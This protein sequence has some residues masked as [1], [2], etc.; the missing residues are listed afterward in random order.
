M[1][2]ETKRKDALNKAVEHIGM[3]YGIVSK[4]AF[5]D[6]LI[7]A[8]AAKPPSAVAEV[9]GKVLSPADG[10]ADALLCVTEEGLRISD[11]L[12]HAD[13]WAKGTKKAKDDEKKEDPIESLR[14]LV[15]IVFEPKALAAYTDACKMAYPLVGVPGANEATLP[16]EWS[17]SY[18]NAVQE[19]LV[20]DFA[21]DTGDT[22][23]SD[24][25]DLPMFLTDATPSISGMIHNDALFT[26]FFAHLKASRKYKDEP[27]DIW[28]DHPGNEDGKDFNHPDFVSKPDKE[29]PAICAFMINSPQF[30]PATRGTGAVATFVNFAPTIEISRCQPYLDIQILTN[31]DPLNSDGVVD[32]MSIA[33]F[34]MGQTAPA[35]GTA[36]HAIATARNQSVLGSGLFKLDATGK[37]TEPLST[38][39]ME[40]F[41]SPQMMTDGDN[42]DSAYIEDLGLE[43]SKVPDT[44]PGGAGSVRNAPVIDRYRPLMT[45][46]GFSIAVTP[47][48]GMM[49]HKTANLDI[50]LHD[51]SRLAEI[52]DLVKPDLY[53]GTELLIEYGW[54]H[55]MGDHPPGDDDMA[56]TAYARFINAMRRKE[57]FK[58]INSSFNFDDVGQVQVK[59]ALSMVGMMSL[60]TSN[61]S[62][63]GGVDGDLKAVKKLQRVIREINRKISRGGSTDVSGETFVSDISTLGKLSSIPPEVTKEIKAYIK[64]NR[65]GTGDTKELAV[66]MEELLGPNG[67]GE[68]GLMRTLSRSIESALYWKNKHMTS[69]YAGDPW[70]IPISPD[71]AGYTGIYN[72]ACAPREDKMYHNK[73]IR[74]L[75]GD[76]ELSNK[77]LKKQHQ[78]GSGKA[79]YVSFGKALFTYAVAPLA[80]TNDFDEI[81]VFFYP[82]NDNA[83]YMRG[84]NIA[85]FPIPWKEFQE[86]FDKLTKTNPAPSIR[87]FLGMLQRKFI[88]PGHAPAWGLASLYEPDKE[89]GNMVMK[90]KMKV[91]GYSKAKELKGGILRGE[92]DKRLAAAYFED[93]NH[94]IA[95]MKF[96]KPRI[97]ILMEAVPAIS[98]N[99]EGEDGK[100]ATILKIHIYDK[101]CTSYTT[102]QQLLQATQKSKINKITEY[103]KKTRGGRSQDAWADIEKEFIADVLAS[104]IIKEIPGS[105][106][107]SYAVQGGFAGV[108]RWVRKSTPSLI[109]GASNSAVIQASVSS[110]NDPQMATIMMLRHRQ[111]DTKASTPSSTRQTGLPLRVVPTALSLT[112]LGCP[113]VT[114]GQQ[115]FVD[116]GTGTTVDNIYAVTGIDHTLVQGEFI[117][118][119]KLVNLDAYGAYET[120]MSSASHS[121][122]AIT[123]AEKASP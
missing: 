45:I 61:V 17:D 109:F 19:Q 54:N 8:S 68:G 9:Q 24:E 115:F 82:F 76:D 29:H 123:E 88:S 111:N 93:E 48:G 10:L 119:L 39:G 94:P 56:S 55:P 66:A 36:N 101:A 2:E 1:S 49:S 100:L 117:T 108:K 92:K 30:S 62:A 104:D 96:R 3:Y 63:G 47:S 16:R 27:E 40:L 13:D 34:L 72:S 65:N 22:V 120:A 35:E 51:R 50:V 110:M 64:A 25:N 98:A 42:R 95:D 14:K 78:M 21:N 116:F 89:S 114:F 79:R 6:M 80:A 112:I 31:R 37:L 59:L 77:D 15:Q 58:V 106:P 23:R 57:K 38:A 71:P 5:V 18:N 26:R 44:V 121:F 103:G 122:K 46:T 67:D 113:L 90:E 74:K 53:G 4:N 7:Q 69:S 97:G 84:R 12:K 70:W 60:D 32:T 33:Q 75:A 118:N 105:D 91:A 43:A 20:E 83:S 85:T 102:A 41:T 86:E 73:K 81:Q 107:K 11:I 99:E 52:G 87:R 28:K